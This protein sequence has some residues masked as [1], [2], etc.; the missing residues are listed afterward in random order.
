VEIQ[1]AL[2]RAREDALNQCAEAEKK[3]LSCAVTQYE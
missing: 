2:E 1:F 3:G